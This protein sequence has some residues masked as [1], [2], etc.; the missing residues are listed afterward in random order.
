MNLLTSD[1]HKERI[2]AAIAQGD[3]KTLDYYRQ[4]LAKGCPRYMSVRNMALNACEYEHCTACGFHPVFADHVDEHGWFHFT[5]PNIERIEV[6]SKGAWLAEVLVAALPNGRW[7]A[8]GT[9]LFCRSG[10]MAEPSVF[11]PQFRTRLEAMRSIL[12]KLTLYVDGETPSFVS[13]LKKR[14]TALWGRTEP[15]QLEFEF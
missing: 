15:V 3:A 6:V 14:I 8:G 1:Q 13:A 5:I 12:S 7:V 11:D 9:A 10:F 4:F 2:E